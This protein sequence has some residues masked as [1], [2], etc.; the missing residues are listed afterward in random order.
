[1]NAMELLVRHAGGDRFSIRVRGH[2]LV[3]D[4]PLS[5]G[6]EDDGPTPTELFVASLA[7]CVGFYA[8][9]FLRRHGL[10]ADGLRIDAQA[11]MSADR[12]ARVASVTLQV[13]GLPEMSEN[14]RKGLLAVVEHCTV[15]NSIRQAPAIEI[16]LADVAGA[17]G[18]AVS[19]PDGP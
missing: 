3:V 8:E 17:E 13:G 11:A 1:V 12:P 2:E 9:R 18:P 10:P 6:G 15:H 4:Q 7:A 14:R 16:D 5:D 19:V